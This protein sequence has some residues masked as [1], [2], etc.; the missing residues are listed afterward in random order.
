MPGIGAL[1]MLAGFAVSVGAAVMGF[2]AAPVLIAW[3]EREP[4][5][6]VTTYGG[7]AGVAWRRER[8]NPVTPA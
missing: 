6:R 7:R 4:V 3:K 2:I 1:A 5:Y 8:R